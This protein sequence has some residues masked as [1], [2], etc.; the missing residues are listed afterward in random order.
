MPNIPE[1]N[2]VWGPLGDQILGVRN[3]QIDA[4]TAMANAAEQVRVAVEG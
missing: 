1:M 4:A 3:L 2:N